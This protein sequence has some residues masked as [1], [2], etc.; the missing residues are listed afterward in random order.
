MRL[1]RGEQGERGVVGRQIGWDPTVRGQR[2][3][4]ILAGPQPG[5]RHRDN[6]GGQREETWRNI[7]E[8]STD[9]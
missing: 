5:L 4:G 3:Y 2:R 8:A 7:L 1:E 9:E 6:A